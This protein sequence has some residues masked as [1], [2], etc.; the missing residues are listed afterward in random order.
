METIREVLNNKYVVGFI[1]VGTI[2]YAGL[3]APTLPSGIAHL[4]ESS[5]MKMMMYALIVF[6]ATQNL[7]VALVVAIAFYVLMSMLREQKIGEGFIDGLRT[8][9][10]F[11]QQISD[12]STTGMENVTEPEHASGTENANGM[13]NATEPEHANEI[14]QTTEPEQTNGMEN[15]TGMETYDESEHQTS[16]EH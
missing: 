12:Q 14:E 2:L 11:Q 8:E 1:F 9:G 4:F 15:A 6:L 7:Q 3:A 10:F 13:E 5:I 16:N